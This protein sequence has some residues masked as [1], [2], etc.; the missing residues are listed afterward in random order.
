MIGYKSE[1]NSR[2]TDFIKQIILAS[3]KQIIFQVLYL[4][5]AWRWRSAALSIGFRELDLCSM[6]EGFTLVEGV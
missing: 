4:P 3:Y 1:N 2:E 6:L 5:A